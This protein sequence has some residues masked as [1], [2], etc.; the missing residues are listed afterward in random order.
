MCGYIN[1]YRVPSEPLLD[2][3]VDQ[4]WLRFPNRG[5]E[6]SFYNGITSLGERCDEQDPFV[7]LA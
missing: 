6:L 3:L 7:S 2:Y 1:K 5:H 4:R